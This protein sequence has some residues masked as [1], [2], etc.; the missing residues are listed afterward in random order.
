MALLP[1]DK[2]LAS[3]LGLSDDE[4]EWFQSEVRKQSALAPEPA[5]VAG[6]ETLITI[7]VSLLIG[8]GTTVASSFFKPKPPEQ[9]KQRN[10]AQ[11]KSLARGGDQ[12]TNNQRT[13]PRY[14]FNSTQ[15]I[16]TLGEII[17]IVYA[18]KEGNFGGVRVNTALLWSQLYSLGGSQMLRGVFM[19]GE[20]PMASIDAKNFAS[21]GNTLTSYD[22][23]NATANELGSRMAV[24]GRYDSG[25]TTRIMPADHLYGREASKDVGNTN[26]ITGPTTDVFGV[27][28]GDAVT[29]GFCASQKPANQTT[30]GLYGFCGNDLAMRPNP[31]FEPMVKPQLVP[32][33]DEGKTK[34]KCIIDEAKW[35]QREKSKVMFSSRSGITSAGLGSIGGTTNYNL[36]SSSDKDTKFGQDIEDLTNTSAWNVDVILQVQS[37]PGVVIVNGKTGSSGDETATAQFGDSNIGNGTV[38]SAVLSRFSATVV[39]CEVGNSV[40]VTWPGTT[41][42]D[43]NKGGAKDVAYI[44]VKVDFDASG[45]VTATDGSFELLKASQFKVTLKHPLTA[46]DPEDDVEVVQYYKIRVESDSRQEIKGANGSVSGTPSYVTVVNSDGDDVSVLQSYSV[47]GG[48]GGLE[49]TN[50]ALSATYSW[51]RTSGTFTLT[52]S[53]TFVS[54]FSIKELY[55]EGCEDIAATVAGRQKAWDDTLILGELYKIGTGL[56]ICTDRTAEPFVSTADGF[57]G[58]DVEVEF[59]TVRTGVVSTN[60]QGVLELD[61][62]DWLSGSKPARNVGTTD[63]HIMRCAIASM[64]TTRP[65]KTVEFGIRSTLGINLSGLTSF[66]TT[67]GYVECD[68][69]ACLDYKGNILNEGTALYSNVHVSSRISTVAERYSFFRI[70]YREAGTA[71]AFTEL[72]NAYG[73]RS[74]TSQSVFNYIQLDMNAIKQWEFQFEPLSGYEIRNHFNGDLYILEARPAPLTAFTD[75]GVTVSMSGYLLGTRTDTN[76]PYQFSITAGRRSQ[77]LSDLGYNTNDANYP[78]GEYSLIDTW[79]KLAESFIYEEINSTAQSPE[80]EITYMNE[81]VPNDT[82]P[83]YDSLALLGLNISSSVEWQQFS[84]FSCY[85]TGGK[86]CR[87]LRDSNTVGATHLLPDIA[88][89]LMTNK[90]YGKGELITDGLI[91]LDSFKDSA[92]WCQARNYFFDGAVADQVNLRQWSADMAAAHLLIFGECNGQYFLKPA[93]PHSGGNLTEPVTIVGLFTAGNIVENSFKLQYLEQ[94]DR[95]PIQVSVRYREERASTDLSNPGIF[96]TVREVLVR[97]ASASSDIERE[98]LDVSDFATNRDHAI[99]AA[100]FIIRM[101]RIPTHT[102]SFQTSFEGVLMKMTPGDYIQIALQSVP[103]SSFNNGVVT[104]EGTLV[105]TSPIAAGST[106]V[107]AWDGS[108]DN[109]PIATTLIVNADGTASPT[110]VVFTAA[111]DDTSTNT[112]QI[113]SISPAQ[114]GT[115]TI[116]AVHM[117]LDRG[118]LEIASGFDDA[119]KWTIEG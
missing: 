13:A 112:Y 44:A 105:S 5:V 78:S 108:N 69:R 116:D 32:K 64:S 117:P 62:D 111:T 99:D 60:S 59:K 67:K 75:S 82:L 26:N 6:V 76:M 91:D 80:H 43:L 86:T 104:T 87:R 34:V 88:W 85:V 106:S 18:L 25:L 23:G 89:D 45:L 73:I 114:D 39:D 11:I 63:G 57:T 119:T 74:S 1:S 28:V 58:R 31:T 102:I 109:P 20:G 4:F 98:S 103:Y 37:T 15:E 56:A 54:W 97:E 70:S 96:P 51:G 118:I 9:Q 90:T 47:S 83:V 113:E 3:L 27:R 94:E 7:G 115:Y 14:G 36:Y 41:K 35:A 17:P 65:C 42:I 8:I 71:S 49:V 2:Y 29:Q 40:V 19:V 72:S 68:E 101:R 16:A 95:S 107:V 24:Y 53:Y 30:F 33:G 52:G 84:Q 93:M 50:Q 48:G 55:Y 21:G 81:I 22:F 12:V 77:A 100:K 61:G 66:N 38:Q 79:G 46:D 92:D 10:P 110:G